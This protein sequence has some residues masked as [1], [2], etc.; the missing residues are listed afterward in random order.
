MY[1]KL[2]LYYSMGKKTNHKKNLLLKFVFSFVVQMYHKSDVR[3]Y[4][5]HHFWA[6]GPFLENCLPLVG[7]LSSIYEGLMGFQ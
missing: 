5:N 4:P 1:T 6:D 2:N 7:I 3:F